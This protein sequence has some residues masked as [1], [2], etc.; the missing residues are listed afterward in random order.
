MKNYLFALNE[1]ESRRISANFGE[2]RRI[3]ANRRDST[4]SIKIQLIA[5]SNFKCKLKIIFQNVP[6]HF[7]DLK[8]I[9][10]DFVAGNSC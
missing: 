9:E 1:A 5:I 2:S 6:E 3:S 10:G 4:E 7:Q 8:E